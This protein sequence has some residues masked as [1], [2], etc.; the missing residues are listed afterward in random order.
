MC[1]YDWWRLL[2]PN[3]DNNSASPSPL[4]FVSFLT[5][6]EY[7]YTVLLFLF[8]NIYISVLYLVLFST[9]SNYRVHGWL[10][11]LFIYSIVVTIIEKENKVQLSY[12]S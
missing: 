5:R 8:L 7:S 9:Y 1:S 6:V 10:C 11:S 12:S 2:R 4:I 3:G